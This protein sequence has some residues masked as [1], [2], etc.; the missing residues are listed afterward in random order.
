MDK[1]NLLKLLQNYIKDR[2]NENAIVFENCEKSIREDKIKM[3]KEKY[4]NGVP[5][6]EIEKLGDILTNAFMGKL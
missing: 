5:K 1:N 6:K 3:I 4:K 2:K